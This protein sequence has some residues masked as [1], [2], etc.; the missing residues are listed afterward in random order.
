MT[1][2]WFGDYEIVKRL[3]VGG[4]ATLY[5][6][7]RHGAAGFARLVALK[8]IHPHLVEQPSFVEM[9]VD[10]ARICSHIR[11]PNVV[12]V[13]E[14]GVI[15]SVPYLVMEYL[16]G[17]SVLDLL[18]QHHRD[19]R[20]LDPELAA[21][22][23]MQV[24]GGLHAAH[25]TRDE[26]GV[27]LD[28]IHRDISPSNIL[29]STD[30]HAKL[31]DF[32]I[33][34]ARNRLSGTEAGNSLKGKY[35]YV[36]P[37]QA[38]R[39]A[40]DRRCDIFSLGVVFWEMLVGRPLFPQDTHVA[41]FHRLTRTEVAAPSTLNPAVPE[42]LDSIVLAMLA[43]EP[44]NRPQIAAEVERRIATAIPGAA[45]RDP[46]ELGA[47]AIEVRDRRAARVATGEPTG[48]TGHASF[49][50]TPRSTRAAS[51]E[52]C[53]ESVVTSVSN[54][55][56]PAPAAAAAR[57]SA[58]RRLQ[59]GVV[60]LLGIGATVGLQLGPRDGRPTPSADAAPVHRSLVEP[61]AAVAAP[62]PTMPAAVA[63][64]TTA[65]SPP[66]A[67]A[68]PAIV[69]PPDV[70]APA[71]ASPPGGPLPPPLPPAVAVTPAVAA[72]APAVAAGLAPARP[73]PTRRSTRVVTASPVPVQATPAPAGGPPFSSMP[74]DDDANQHAPRVDPRTVTVKQTPIV[75]DFD[76]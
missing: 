4:M 63:T 13:E 52:L 30:G 42:V 25:E 18:V 31:I 36:A 44:A 64:P 60:A 54:A 39:K 69:S 26:D 50:P 40:V 10:E 76:H 6:A 29:V 62:T 59:L 20:T 51:S 48:L 41:L 49:S 34:K 61:S 8:M 32:G 9:F 37:E 55:R 70:S 65:S 11:H 73:R 38:T 16:D 27:P 19:R 68:A 75:P 43:H 47:L 24:A 67:V 66:P 14:L 28:V 17:C 56:A 46:S 7:R 33:A 35:R 15:D 53:F 21:R 74:F 1:S 2:Q 5:L 72:V 22:V 23:V 58:R 57:R 71:I 45:N 3:R 12:H